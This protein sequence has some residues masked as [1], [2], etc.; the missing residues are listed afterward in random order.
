MSNQTAS[1]IS[2]SICKKKTY[3]ILTFNTHERYQTQLSKTQH[4][5]YAFNSQ[6]MKRWL[7]EH[8][9]V[10]D[11]YYNLPDDC[12]YTGLGFDFILAQSKFGQI[13]AAYKINQILKLPIVALEHTLPVKEWP[14]DQLSQMKQLVGDINVYISKYSADEWGLPQ[15]NRNVIYHSIDADL[16]KP[17]EGIVKKRQ[18]LSVVHNFVDR[19]YCCNYSGWQRI[20]KDL[21]TRV[22][23]DTP[24]LSKAADSVEQLVREYQESTVFLNTSTLSPV[25]MALLEAMSCGCAVVSTATCM[26]PEI[27]EDGV[28]GFI[29]NDEEQ[30]KTHIQWLLDHPDAAVSMGKNARQT[31]LDKFSEEQFINNWNNIFDK[32]YGA[33]K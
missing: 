24:G 21:P 20:T 6:G 17:D 31:I 32:A 11:R 12:I 7:T 19:D 18:I 22:V 8:A 5:F 2:K 10:P 16:F 30:L 9:P 15:E 4:N 26:I 14:Y 3:N 29:S 13:Q 27:I 23:G 25:P 28:N 33:K 1:I